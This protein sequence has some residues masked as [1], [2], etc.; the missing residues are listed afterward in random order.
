MRSTKILVRS[1]LLGACVPVLAQAQ[2]VVFSEN[3]DAGTGAGRFD[4]FTSGTAADYQIDYNYDYST[5]Q[6]KKYS[7][8]TNFTSQP[9]PAAPGG[10]STK[11][12]RMSLGRTN[13]PAIALAVL[14]KLPD[15]SHVSVS[16]NY[17]IS[18]DL[19]MNYNGPATGG[20]NSTEA[21]SFGLNYDGTGVSGY[22]PATAA[23]GYGF[24]MTGEG[25]NGSSD[26]QM[27]DTGD[28]IDDGPSYSKLNGSWPATRELAYN[29]TTGFLTNGTTFR[30]PADASNS[31]WDTL[32]ASPEYET[33]G[34][35]GK[36][37]VSVVVEG[38][39]NAVEWSINGKTA[40][41]LYLD[42]SRT[43]VPSL[44]YTDPFANDAGTVQ[45]EQFALYD[46]IIVT[47]LADSS[48][49]IGTSGSFNDPAKWTA[50]V[51]NGATADAVFQGAGAASNVTVNSPVT[52]RSMQF[53]SDAYTIG[54]TSTITLGT[55]VA[56]NAGTHTVSAPVKLNNHLTVYTAANTS[57]TMSNL[58]G[59]ATK[60]I[61]KTG[62]GT[63]AVNKI[64]ADGL[65]MVAG[66]LQL[67]PG[68]GNSRIASAD[69]GFDYD[70]LI[71][72][73][74]NALIL[75]YVPRI[76]SG[77]P[78]K[79]NNP[80]LSIKINQILPAYNGGDWHGTTGITSS[81]AANTPNT[82]VGYAE[83]STLF[84]AAG[85]TFNGEAVDGSAVLIRY[86]YYGDGNL[87]GKV[88]A[89]DFNFLASNFGATVTPGS[90][91][92]SWTEGDYNLDGIVDSSD[93]SMLATNYNKDITPPAPSLADLIPEPASLSLAL[94]GTLTAGLRRRRR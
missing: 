3:F 21:A 91:T 5:F 81:L 60:N 33:L 25:G 82:G 55:S 56:V 51:P 74:N 30:S 42:S 17:K 19:W 57:L 9:I 4:E 37:W 78:T 6:Y 2:T 72:L 41:T 45:N 86:T 29:H 44:G 38:H 26:Y 67:L 1:I 24:R 48:K 90:L 12:L 62:E 46:N 70:T 54:G 23:N 79:N 59:D 61:T 22:S 52:L 18:F 13:T 73:T 16:N 10:V 87:D 77:D 66:T 63:W 71:D 36:H 47:Q 64:R 49:L 89:L 32:F 31:Y 20:S 76:V 75:D 8:S 65:S 27:F 69:I 53:D 7:D 80:F 92:P 43:G 11:G 83:A 15:T 88:N 14:P 93:F 94:L 40:G 84:G 58:T 68:G 35:P 39:G 28:A 50:G 34:A 85:G